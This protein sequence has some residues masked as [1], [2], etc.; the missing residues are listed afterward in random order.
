MTIR[1]RLFISNILMLVIPALL[2]L[3]VLAAALLL[4]FSTALPSSGYHLLS[5]HELSEARGELTEARPTG[6][7]PPGQR[8]RRI[9][10]TASV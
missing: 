9:W 4:F 3:L 5:S 7:P 8:A 6:S 1:K 10:P 2:A